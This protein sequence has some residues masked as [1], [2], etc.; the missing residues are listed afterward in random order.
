[1]E[2]GEQKLAFARTVNQS[3]LRNFFAEAEQVFQYKIEWEIKVK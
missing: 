2:T 3:R 1:M